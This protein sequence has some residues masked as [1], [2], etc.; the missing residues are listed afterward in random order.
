ME[1]LTTIAGDAAD[2]D[3]ADTAAALFAEFYRLYLALSNQW[4]RTLEMPG[5][6]NELADFIGS[7]LGVSLW[8]KQR[9]LEELSAHRRLEMEID[10]LA[11]AIRE[12]APRVEAARAARWRGLGAMN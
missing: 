7:R 2:E 5:V 10:I 12:L 3:L 9:L 4:A 8:T 1:A 6:P 11:D